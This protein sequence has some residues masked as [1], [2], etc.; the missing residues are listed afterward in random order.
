MSLNSAM[1][2]RY[3]RRALNGYTNF[4]SL[5]ERSW[6]VCPAERTRVPPAIRLPGSCERIQGLQRDRS[7]EGERRLIDGEVIEHAA[8]V[9]HLFRN[10]DLVDA[11][12]YKHGA[13]SKPGFG[14]SRIWLADSPPVERIARAELVSTNGGSEYFG[15]WLQDDIPLSMLVGSDPHKIVMARRQYRHEQGYRELLGEPA[16]RTV[17]RA[18]VESLTTYTDYGQNR[19]RE[20]RYRQLRARLRAMV[21]TGPDSNPPGAYLKRGRTGQLRVIVNEAE[22]EATMRR[23]RFRIVEPELLSASD[24]AAQ[25]LNAAVVVSVE[26]SH[27][28]NVIYSMADD[29]TLVILQPPDRFNMAY[30]EY[31]D[32]MGMTCCFVVGRSVEGGFSVDPADIERVIDL[33]ARRG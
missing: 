26:G 5:A 8:S 3:F 12:L 29:A 28:S 31:T 11:Y 9:A 32:R 19:S 15:C 27:I 17:S 30:K 33:A 10:V 22:V 2:R 24:I 6:I 20:E 25:T 14:G 16:P 18:V 21:Q 7:W 23:L 1:L 13:L 4:E